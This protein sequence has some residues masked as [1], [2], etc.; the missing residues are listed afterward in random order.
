[1]TSESA[2]NNHHHN[3][4]DTVPA[5]PEISPVVADT[6]LNEAPL[7][8]ARFFQGVLDIDA[9]YARR[10]PAMPMLSVVRLHEIDLQHAAA[11]ISKQ[12]GAASLIVD[13]DRTT[14]A[15]QFT[16]VYGSMLAQC[17]RLDE[18]SALDRRRWLEAMRHDL[19]KPAFLWDADRWQKDYVLASVHEYYVNMYA[20]SPVG[21]AAAVR[22]TPAAMG[23]LLD[24]LDQNWRTHSQTLW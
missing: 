22:I 10:F 14:L 2:T 15:V 19:K 21:A 20:F 9:E 13:V 6:I 24:W 11:T 8:L 7:L 18:L 4:D 3:E 1:M 23:K 17:F 12:D 5:R 16:F